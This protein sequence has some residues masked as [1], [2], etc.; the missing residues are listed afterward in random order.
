MASRAIH[1]ELL[2]DMTTDSF[3]NSLRCFTS[4]RGPVKQIRSDQG[5]NFIGAA[6]EFKKACNENKLKKYTNENNIEFVVNVPNASHMG[7]VWERQIRT[8]RNVLNSMFSI[9]K[10]RIDT[11]TLRTFFYEAM[12]IV[13][14]RPLNAL[15]DNDMTIPLTPN[16]LITLKNKI[17]APP[18][19]EFDDH[20]MYSRKRWRQVQGLA[21]TFW[22]RWTKEYLQTLQPRQ[23][24]P[25]TQRNIKLGDIVLIKNEL[26]SRNN[27]PLAKVI[28]ILPSKDNLVR[29]VKLQLASNQLDKNGKRLVQPTQLERPIHKLVLLCS[30]Q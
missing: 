10:N 19:G 25:N 16:Q 11:S 12:A 18:P 24:W 3:I 4:I 28:Q 8:V 13:N 26:T 9:H 1:I 21:T 22:S 29:K 7:G 5:T 20:D 17:A 2:D 14:S 30:T 27:W 15:N 6:N 23:K